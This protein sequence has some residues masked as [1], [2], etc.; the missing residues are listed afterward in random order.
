M[1]FLI[2]YREN[3]LLVLQELSY[4]NSSTVQEGV[5]QIPSEFTSSNYKFNEYKVVS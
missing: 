2:K 4:M 3:I 1:C 5:L